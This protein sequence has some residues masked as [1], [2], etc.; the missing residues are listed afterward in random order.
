MFLKKLFFAVFFFFQMLNLFILL[1]LLLNIGCHGSSHYCNPDFSS[2]CL[3]G[4]EKY[5]DEDLYVVNCSD[6]GFKSAEILQH[7]P[8]QTQVNFFIIKITTSSCY[9]E[10]FLGVN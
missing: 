4:I 9:I 1:S 8:S 10:I 3:C 2:K 7:L 6:T 5:N